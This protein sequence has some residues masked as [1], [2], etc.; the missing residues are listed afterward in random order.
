MLKVRGEVPFVIHHKQQTCKT[1]VYFLLLYMEQK[2]LFY[3]E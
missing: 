2:L 3:Q 1:E